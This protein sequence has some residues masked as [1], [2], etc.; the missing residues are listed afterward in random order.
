M[1]KSLVRLHQGAIW[2]RRVVID[3]AGVV[4]FEYAIVAACVVA[5]LLAVFGTDDTSGINKALSA[6]IGRIIAQLP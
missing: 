4:S 1:L 3:K 5:A 2:L 6:G